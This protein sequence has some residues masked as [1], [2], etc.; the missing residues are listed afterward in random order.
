MQSQVW[1]FYS[2]LYRS[3]CINSGTV[4]IARNT[5]IS[6]NVSLFYI[7]VLNFHMN[8]ILIHIHWFVP[9][10]PT[11]D[12]AKWRNWELKLWL[13]YGWKIHNYLS[14]R[15]LLPPKM[16]LG[17]S[18]DLEQKQDL[19]SGTLIQDAQSW[20]CI[21]TTVPDAHSK[22]HMAYDISGTTGECGW[23]ALR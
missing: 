12:H 10:M 1:V 7:S 16:C 2:A 22:Y 9:Q 11:K 19:K 4:F 17:R 6:K 23:H 14:E 8:S 15:P 20:S 13:P 21:L 18:W 5:E 3:T